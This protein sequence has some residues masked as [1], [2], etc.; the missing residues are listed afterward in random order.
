MVKI[1]TAHTI[2]KWAGLTAGLWLAILG[3]TGIFLDHPEWRWL[4]QTNINPAFLPEKT[5]KSVAIGVVRVVRANPANT[6]EIVAGG[7][8]GLWFSTDGGQHWN[9]SLFSPYQGQAQTYAIE[10]DPLIGWDR[11][12]FATDDGIW[13]SEN[14]GKSLVF[15]SLSGERVTSLSLGFSPDNLTGVINKG[16]KFFNLNVK[17]PDRPDWF[18]LPPPTSDSLPSS[19]TLYRYVID[20]HFGSGLGDK[21][22]SVLVNDAMAI[23]WIILGLTGF[24]YWLLPKLWKRKRNKGKE[25]SATQKRTTLMWLFNSHSSTTGILLIIPAI[26]LAITGVFIG[27]S[28]ELKNWLKSI[29]VP[30]IYQTPAY[31]V[32]NW[33]GW[34]DGIATYRPSLGK[35]SVATR[36]GLFTT[37]DSGQL[38]TREFAGDI[39]LDAARR[40]RQIGNYYYIANGMGGKV[41]VQVGQGWQMSKEFDSWVGKH[42]PSDVMQWE[43]GKLAWLH[44]KDLYLTDSSVREMD[45]MRK[46]Q[47]PVDDGV[48]LFTVI[49]QLHNG[50]MLHPDWKWVNDFFAVLSLILVVTGLLRWWKKKWLSHRSAKKHTNQSSY[51]ARLSRHS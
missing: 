49:R 36:I 40:V 51:T 1:P 12:W 27:H 44:G 38:W 28:S 19:I 6:N 35:Y 2:H 30:R 45:A 48:P 7:P 20:L 22:T 21:S 34:V 32:S 43:D 17:T 16:E 10:L 13:S 15:R 14:G 11:L 25:N 23:G 41:Y 9:R 5:A 46:I 26:Y 37:E 42:L 18:E 24:L 39:D 31:S 47:L 50:T 8:R 33:T 3:I 29:D 4:W